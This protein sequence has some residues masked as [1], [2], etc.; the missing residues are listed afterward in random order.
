MR[1]QAKHLILKMLIIF[2]LIISERLAKKFESLL[3]FLCQIAPDFVRRAL[4]SDTVYVF[5]HLAAPQNTSSSSSIYLTK[6]KL[7][8]RLPACE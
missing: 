2:P 4:W 1:N 8:I 3:L 5:V 7:A 6:K